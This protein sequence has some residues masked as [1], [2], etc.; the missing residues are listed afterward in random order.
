MALA[1]ICTFIASPCF[2]GGAMPELRIGTTTVAGF[3][4]TSLG[5]WLNADEPVLGFTLSMAYDSSELAVVGLDV[6]GLAADADVVLGE[7]FPSVGAVTLTVVMDN[8]G[9]GPA[10]ILPGDDLLVA[11]VQ[12]VPLDL[13][14]VSSAIEFEDG[15]A[16]PIAMN[17]VD[18]ST[19]MVSVIDGLSLVGGLVVGA[20]PGPERFIVEDTEIVSLETGA[21]R[22]LMDNPNGAVEAFAVG[23]AHDPVE[24]ALIDITLSG[25]VTEAVGAEFVTSSFSTAGGTLTVVL[26]FEPPFAAQVIPVGSGHHIAN[27]EYTVLAEL[28]DGVDP[29]ETYTLSF[30]DG[31]GTPPIDNLLLIPGVPQV[32]IP[33][34]QSGVVTALPVALIPESAVKFY[35]GGPGLELDTLGDP[36]DASSPILRGSTTEICFYYTSEFNLQGFQLAVCYDCELKLSN[37]RVD[38]TIVDAIGAEFVNYQIDSDPFDG[39][40]C[41]LVAGVLLDALPPFDGQ[42]VPPTAQPLIIGCVDAT[43]CDLPVCAPQPESDDDGVVLYCGSEDLILGPD[44]VPIDA[45]IAAAPGDTVDVCFYY[46]SE[47]ASIQGFQLAIC[48]DCSLSAGSFSVDGIVEM[49]GA[50]WVNYNIDEDPNDGDGCEMVAGILLDIFPPFD[51]QT[52]PPTDVPLLIGCVDMTVDPTAQCEE[53]LNIEFCDFINGAGDVLI[54]NIA[55]I[56]F[57]SGQN[58]PKFCC[59]VRVVGDDPCA[60]LELGF[61]NF[62]NGLGEVPIENIA[63]IDYTSYQD[64]GFFSG[65][66]CLDREPRFVRGD[67]NQ[68]EKHD[69]ADAASILGQ[70]FSGLVVGCDDA[71]DANDDGDINLADSVYILRY[72]LDESAPPPMPFPA[73]GIDVGVDTLGCDSFV[74]CAN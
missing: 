27:Y 68:D 63:V 66:I 41:E 65:E 39:D 48:Y 55:V 13:G 34:L 9:F 72:L 40:G 30:Q 50:E 3:A 8:D 25:T 51:G 7:I 1:V 60:C 11:E 26:D 19:G 52:V 61:C 64:I 43:V 20:P 28:T 33:E 45:F 38:G 69:L 12:I 29:V 58:L 70:Q 73:C 47:F 5:V 44:G 16:S 59:A 36:I 6:A 21:V 18:L 32:V 54:E 2:G 15:L 24:L 62:I 37:F 35:V 74:Y 10:S 56:D 14:L 49:V 42:T 22:V 4:P 71:C 46:T 17:T 67:C 23:V 57:Q 53:F 31:L